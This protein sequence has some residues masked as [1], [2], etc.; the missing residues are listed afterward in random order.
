MKGKPAK[1]SKEEG[2]MRRRKR[3]TKTLMIMSKSKAPSSA[4]NAK[5][6]S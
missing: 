2:R 6:W 5:W 3:V 4:L 1:N